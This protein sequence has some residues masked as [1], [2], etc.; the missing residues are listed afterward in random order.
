MSDDARV[1]NLCRIG[2]HSP[3]PKPSDHG[4]GTQSIEAFELDGP[5]PQMKLYDRRGRLEKSFGGESGEVDLQQLDRA[6]E[7]LLGET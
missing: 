4:A 5:L 1:G 6:V 3:L 7:E 2:L